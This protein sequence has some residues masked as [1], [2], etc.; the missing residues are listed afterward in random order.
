V[1]R[2]ERNQPKK[3]PR[4]EPQNGDRQ[5]NGRDELLN[6]SSGGLN[7][8]QAIGRLNAGPFQ[9]IV[10]ERVLVGSQIERRGVFEDQY[11]H[12]PRI[13][14]GQKRVEERDNAARKAADDRER[15]LSADQPPEKPR[16]GL[17]L[18]RYVGYRIDNAARN[19]EHSNGQHGDNYP[20]AE[21]RNDHPRTRLPYNSQHRRQIAKRRETVLPSL[22]EAFFIFVHA[23]DCHPPAATIALHGHGK[24]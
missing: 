14:I 19:P 12:V 6:Q 7:H 22:P 5:R 15:E 3:Q 13:S 11:A 10:K 21:S 20:R 16:N 4:R 9:T 17:M 8:H 2:D 1:G 23:I 24:T 18:Y